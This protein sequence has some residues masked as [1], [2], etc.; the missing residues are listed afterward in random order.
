MLRVVRSIHCISL[1][2]NMN[3]NEAKAEVIERMV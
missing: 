3:N 1:A 2:N